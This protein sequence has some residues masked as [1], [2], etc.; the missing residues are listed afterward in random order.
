MDPEDLKYERLRRLIMEDESF[1]K[2]VKEYSTNPHAFGAYDYM[3]PPRIKA[4]PMERHMPDNDKT[5]QL[6]AMYRKLHEE[7][8]HQVL[9]KQIR[10]ER[11]FH[12]ARPLTPAAF[13][14]DHPSC[15]GHGSHDI[16]ACRYHC[17]KLHKCLEAQ[18]KEVMGVSTHPAC[19][20]LEFDK[21]CTE[22]QKQ[23]PHR[24]ECAIKFEEKAMDNEKKPKRPRPRSKGVERSMEYEDRKVA[25]VAFKDLPVGHCFI[26]RNHI[27]SKRPAQVYMK[28]D[29]CGTSGETCWGVSLETGKRNLFSKSERV[30]PGRGRFAFDPELT[31]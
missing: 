2:K 7:K 29:E 18:G 22:C 11:E 20:G 12:P 5:A 4:R 24:F 1:E 30:I 10:E 9:E 27:A 16:D 17:M 3:E 23:C 8:P 19:F 25:L 6:M 14:D 28:T 31:E 13:S 21:A 15:F 26:S